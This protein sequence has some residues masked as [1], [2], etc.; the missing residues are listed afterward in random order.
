MDLADSLSGRKLYRVVRP[1]LPSHTYIISN[2]DSRRIHFDPT[3]TDFDLYKQTVKCNEIFLRFAHRLGLFGGFRANRVCELILISGGFYYHLNRS[4]YHV[5]GHSLPAGFIGVKRLLGKHPRGVISYDN[6]EAIPGNNI[7]LI[8]DTIA[9]GA[10]LIDSINYYLAKMST[11]KKIIIF[12][13]AGALPGAKRLAKMENIFRQRAVE[14]RLFFSDGIFGLA[15]DQTDMFYFHPDSILAPE[16]KKAASEKLGE[17]LG[18]RMCVIWDW[19]R[20]NKDPIGHLEEVIRVCERL[21]EPAAAIA[22]KARA[23][24]TDRRRRL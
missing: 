21:G 18:G 24:L 6:L 15:E 20:R 12:T 13:I 23:K 10:T 14:L 1:D 16:A 4:F 3:I 5:F 8:G 17:A 19:G 22:R 11:V 7:T 2:L 9:T